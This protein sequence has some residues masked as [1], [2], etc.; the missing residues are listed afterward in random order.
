MTARPRILLPHPILD[1][2]GGGEV[3]AAAV[4]AA[5]KA[6]YDITILTLRP[7]DWRAVARFTG[8]AIEPEEVALRVVS[9]LAARRLPQIELALLQRSILLRHARKLVDQFD[10][11]ISVNN[12]IDVGRRAVQYV[13]F[14]WGYWP[15]PDADLR[16]FHRIAGVLPL[17]YRI[18]DSIAHVSPAAI[19]ANRT[20]VNSNWTGAKFRQ[21]YGGETTTVYPP[22]AAAPLV[23]WSDRENAFLV[24]GR[25]FRGKRIE[26]SLRIVERVRAAGHAVRLRVIGSIVDRA[27]F[28]EIRALIAAREWAS[29]HVNVSR[30]EML[31]MMSRSRYGLHAM[32]DEHFGMAP[33][34]MAR[35]GCI[36]F[37]PRSGGQV[38]IAGGDDR[39]VYASDDEAV[40]KISAVLSSPKAQSELRE[41]LL[42]RAQAFAPERFADRIRA[43]V[44]EELVRSSRREE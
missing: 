13:H 16:W 35:N 29:L 7:I 34:E 11:T 36:V 27:Y 42:T 28:R 33:A 10:L 44:A 2:R 25:L 20:L 15:R 23:S 37:V 43:V 18:A 26:A 21:L 40:E 31:E 38:E 14:P 5:L 12:E 17:Y 9:P 39:L 41:M 3:V 30:E 1:P 6:D 8:Y 24:I 32:T 19:A 22:V 4:I